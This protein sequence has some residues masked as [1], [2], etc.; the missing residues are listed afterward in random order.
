MA[1]IEVNGGFP[2][3]FAETITTAG[4]EHRWPFWTKYMVARNLGANVVQMYF[5]EKDF[6]AGQNYITLPVASAILPHGEWRGPVENRTVWLKSLVGSSAV[7]ITT[8]QR[9][10]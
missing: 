1:G 2:S 4:R 3:V 8:F 6:T 9:R 7:E 5:T 10:G